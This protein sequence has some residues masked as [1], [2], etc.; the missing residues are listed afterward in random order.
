MNICFNGILQEGFLFDGNVKIINASLKF[1]ITVATQKTKFNR[2]KNQIYIVDLKRFSNQ[3][4]DSASK[5]SF[6]NS[7]DFVCIHKIPFYT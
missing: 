2:Y 7:F 5:L 6:L 4:S 1:L 3:R